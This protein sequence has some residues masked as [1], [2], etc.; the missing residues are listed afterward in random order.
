M[1]DLLLEDKMTAANCTKEA[2]L[3]KDAVLLPTFYILVFVVVVVINACGTRCL[4]RNWKKHRIINIFII[5]LGLANL[6][7]ILTHP[8]IIDL[9]LKGN[10][11]DFGQF[12]C[13]VTRFCFKLN[14]YGSIGFLACISVYRYL[15]IVHPMK[16]MGKITTTH[17]V[18]IS[19][20]VWILASVGSL[21][22]VIYPK[23]SGN[24]TESKEC[25][26]ATDK[27]HIEEYFYYNLTWTVFGFCIPFII[28]AGCYGHV[29]LV[30]CRSNTMT[31]EMKQQLLKLL[32][33]L[34]VL[35][36]LCY[37][38]YHVLKNLSVYAKVRCCSGECPNWYDNVSIARYVSRGLVSLNSALN[39]LVN[40]C[41][42]EDMGA[43]F[44]QQ[45]QEYREMFSRCFKLKSSSEPVPQAEKEAEPAL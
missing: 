36:S 10:K 44:R 25:L 23:Q 2:N 27:D 5:N 3:S 33:V 45:L 18:V 11:W 39:P 31:K 13:K 1:R 19:V 20:L 40:M 34:I 14:L 4:V 12:F 42:S 6:L 17:S 21:P 22:D 16:V 15:S 37:T 32:V 26:P 29:T 8:F 28:I 43:Q 7:Y 30:I 9:Y 38:P 24:T 35:F 41:V